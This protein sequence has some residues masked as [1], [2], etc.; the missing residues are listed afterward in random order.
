MQTKTNL[1]PAKSNA[2]ETLVLFCVS[3]IALVGYMFILVSKS[4]YMQSYEVS[5]WLGLVYT[6]FS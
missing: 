1:K 4:V 5:S 3:L 2:H 6:L